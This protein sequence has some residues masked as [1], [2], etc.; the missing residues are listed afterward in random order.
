MDSYA[1]GGELDAQIEHWRTVLEAPVTPLP[2]EP[3]RNVAADAELCTTVLA[4]EHTDALLR[5]APAAFRARMDEL[6][7]AGLATALTRW[8]GDAVHLVELEGH[9]RQ[10]APGVDLS[11]TVGWFTTVYPVLLD[12]ADSDDPAAVIKRTKE[13]LRAVPAGGLGYLALRQQGALPAPAVEPEIAFSYF[14][15]L[16]R[17]LGADAPLTPASESP[18]R[19]E[20]PGNPRPHLLEISGEVRD[21]QLRLACRY[22]RTAHRREQIQDLLD[23]YAA[24]LIA[25]VEQARDDGGQGL[26]PSDFPRARLS[27]ATLDSFLAQLNDGPGAQA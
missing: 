8:S 27:Q 24:A 10:D 3:G 14:G 18:G 17:V 6:L 7:V 11:R 19:T 1:S 12:G 9:G 23:E 22:A 13:H 15:Q 25:M 16:D 21:G 2:R 5:S 4:A 20:D 26:T